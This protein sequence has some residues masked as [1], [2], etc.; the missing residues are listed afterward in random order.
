[1]TKRITA[2]GESRRGNPT[3]RICWHHFDE[4]CGEKDPYDCGHGLHSGLYLSSHV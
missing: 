1:M 4:Q 3:P 2:T